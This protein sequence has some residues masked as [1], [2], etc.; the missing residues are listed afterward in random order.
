MGKFENDKAM[1]RLRLAEMDKRI[2]AAVSLNVA[3]CVEELYTNGAPCS[4]HKK[5]T[6]QC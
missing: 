2:E 4:V 5:L 3:C 1:L 6:D